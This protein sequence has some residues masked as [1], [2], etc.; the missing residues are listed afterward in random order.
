MKTKT[1][2]EPDDFIGS[3]QLI[4][5]SSYQHEINDP[6]YGLSMAYKVAWL[7][8]GSVDSQQ[9][10]HVKGNINCLISLQDGMIKPYGTIEELCEHLNQLD[11]RP[12][13]D[14]EVNEL[15][16]LEGNRFGKQHE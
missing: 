1:I 5:R 16:P 9:F 15:L 8:S 6:N 10:R 14:Q 3:G 2:F 13:T 11:Y 12:M 7:T 4:I